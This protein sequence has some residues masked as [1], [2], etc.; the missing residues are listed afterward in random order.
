MTLFFFIYR[1]FVIV[2]GILRI[3]VSRSSCSFPISS[4]SIDSSTAVIEVSR[5]I[6][7][8]GLGSFKV[9]AKD[10]KVI[11]RRAAGRSVTVGGCGLVVSDSEFSLVN[12]NPF[13]LACSSSKVRVV[14]R[15]GPSA[16]DDSG[17]L[18]DVHTHQAV[19]IKITPHN[20]A[21]IERV[22]MPEPCKHMNP[23]AKRKHTM[24]SRKHPHKT[25]FKYISHP[26]DESTHP[27][28]SNAYGKLNMI[29]RVSRPSKGC[30][31]FS[32]KSC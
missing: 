13:C 27:H 9:G 24:L 11:D 21:I 15:L 16:S 28:I 22:G 7:L 1:L 31:R 8:R 17:S 18:H 23:N 14:V 12:L 2:T 4:S 32:K 29:A 5:R 3:L 25:W 26:A 30:F 19:R 6:F 20:V 10:D